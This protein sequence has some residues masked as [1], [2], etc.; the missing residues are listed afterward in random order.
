ML[1]ENSK[2]N[3]NPGPDKIDHEI[4]KISKNVLKKPLCMLFN[5]IIKE[6][7]I[8]KEWKINLPV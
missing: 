3:K 5:K 2:R 4:L 1:I 8:P 7:Y 6:E